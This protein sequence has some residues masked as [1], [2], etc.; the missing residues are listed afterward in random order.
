M[1][2]V[3]VD[4]ASIHYETT[5][6]G[7]L[8]LCLVHGAGGWA[9]G[10]IRQLEG[11]ADRARIV[12]MDLPGH[13]RSGG[14]PAATI[15]DHVAFVR[16]FIRAIGPG[17]IVLGG[18][19]MGGAVAL[20]YALEHPG[21]LAGLVLIGT[22]ARLRVLPQIFEMLDRDY[23]QAVR[24]ITDRALSPKTSRAIAETMA[25]Q[26][27]ERPR[28]AMVADFRACDG[29]DVMTRL[30]E[31]SVPTLVLCGAD[32]QMAPPKYAEFL[33]E[34]IPAA[35]LAVIADAGHWAHLEQAEEANERIRD[36]L[37]ALGGR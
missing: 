21:D 29:F 11:L 16:A 13:A 15:A 31:V 35:Q 36:F 22:G 19:S 18:H 9:G 34:K 3:T 28:E 23:R 30:A 4:G 37:I 25:S 32:D 20:A 10:W 2:T 8:T 6:G 17:R 27:A 14:K 12:A 33:R 5:G 7:P 24:F 26:A 1:P